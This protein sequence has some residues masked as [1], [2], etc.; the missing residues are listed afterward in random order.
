MLQTD[1]IAVKVLLVPLSKCE[2]KMKIIQEMKN[3]ISSLPFFSLWGKW[4]YWH[5]TELFI[6][7]RRIFWRNF[8]MS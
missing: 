4:K 5:I 2:K 8:P 1:T 7:S 3:I 6:N